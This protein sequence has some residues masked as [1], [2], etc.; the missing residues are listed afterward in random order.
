[1]WR[2]SPRTNW[3]RPWELQAHCSSLPWLQTSDGTVV[4]SA[5]QLWQAVIQLNGEVCLPASSPGAQCW[6]L[7]GA[8]IGSVTPR[9]NLHGPEVSS[10]C[11]YLLSKLDSSKMVCKRPCSKNWTA[12]QQLLFVFLLFVILLSFGF[13]TGRDVHFRHLPCWT[14]WLL[15]QDVCLRF[16]RRHF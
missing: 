1:M 6:E 15:S 11:K 8:Y 13:K 16:H 14:F 4:L 5:L 9:V 2:F 10:D 12:K 3:Q 7:W